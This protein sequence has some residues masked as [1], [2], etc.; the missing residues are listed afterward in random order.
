MAT[1][2]IKRYGSPVLRKRAEVILDI[3]DGIK[4][5]ASDILETMYS[6]RGVGLAAP[7]VGILLRLCVIDVDPK[8]NFPIVMINP[9]I[10]LCENKISGE[11]GC[12][13]FP[14]FYEDVRRYEKVVARYT[15]LSGKKQEVKA[16]GFLARAVQHEIDHLDAKLFIDYLP[17]WKRKLIEKEIKKKK[18]MG[19]W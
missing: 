12:L 1:L 9:E 15:G 8:R 17:Q 3:D 7:Q 18:K 6:A 10:I 14:G 5:L 2:K 11:E 4:K 13:S 19:A 16:Q